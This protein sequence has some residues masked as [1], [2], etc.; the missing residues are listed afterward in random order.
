MNHD[1]THWADYK[2]TTAGAGTPNG[3]KENNFN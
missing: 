3:Q 1:A 2:K